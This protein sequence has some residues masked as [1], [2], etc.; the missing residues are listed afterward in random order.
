M[1]KKDNHRVSKKIH[2]RLSY[3]NTTIAALF[4]V[5]LI[6]TGSGI[7]LP[8]L[9]QQAYASS[10]QS[11]GLSAPPLP[12]PTQ[13]QRPSSQVQPS[14]STSLRISTPVCGEVSTL[15]LGSTGTKVAGLQR[16]LTQLGY[17][18]LLGQSGIDGKFATSTQN[19]VKKFQEDSMLLMKSQENIMLPVDGKVGPIT[20]RALCYKITTPSS[21]TTTAPTPSTPANQQ[22]Q[23][24]LAAKGDCGNRKNYGIHWTYN[25]G[26]WNFVYDII[27]G[28]G[29]V[30]Y[31]IKAGNKDLFNSIT[32]PQFGIEYFDN[33]NKVMKS[34]ILRFCDPNGRSG[35][36]TW[37]Q[38][39][40]ISSDNARGIDDLHWTYYMKFNGNDLPVGTLAINYDIVIRWKPVSNCEASGNECHRFIP[41]VRFDWT[42]GSIGNK[43]PFLNK[44]T[45]FYRL[46]YGNK[47][48]Y[49]V[50]DA[51]SFFKNIPKAFRQPLLTKERVFSAVSPNGNGE[52]D[53]IHTA[54]YLH[55]IEIPGCTTTAFD[56]VHMHW[57][58]GDTR[59]PA[60]YWIRKLDPMIEPSNDS[61]ISGSTGTPYLV[62]GQTIDV[63][64]VRD[65][66]GEPVFP[67]NPFLKANGQIISTTDDRYKVTGAY[68]TIVW[69]RSS[70]QNEKTDTF[71]R[72]G[73]FVLKLSLF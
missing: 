55:F 39:P 3:N 9:Q 38:L 69:Y 16:V 49:P 6:L 23:Q 33:D 61:S 48:I 35:T 40:S 59:V 15:Q 28:L 25:R 11:E 62:P 72:H 54:S 10:Q 19:A 67:D 27:D 56:C 63:A 47:G 45:A 73:I 20:W 31:E 65:N 70:V 29:L 7:G 44:F 46:D 18:P 60:N 12:S 26:P 32:M 8:L 52:I 24:Q 22:Q 4:S 57:R 36:T 71:F 58:W 51:D 1:I 53:N 68:K 21:S 43:M 37:A 17:G 34:R 64:V 41:K 5:I 30:L 42:D 50:K 13:V 2:H 14:S 66:P